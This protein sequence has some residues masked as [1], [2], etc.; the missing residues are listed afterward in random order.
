[1]PKWIQLAIKMLPNSNVIVIMIT[2]IGMMINF[3]INVFGIIM[4][5]PVLYTDEIAVK[6]FIKNAVSLLSSPSFYQ[7]TLPAMKTK[8]YYHCTNCANL[9]LKFGRKTRH[10]ICLDNMFGPGVS[11]IP[12]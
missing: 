8:S 4:F 12:A 3:T 10:K 7:T 11:G 9:I 6:A 1:M 5:S 2:E